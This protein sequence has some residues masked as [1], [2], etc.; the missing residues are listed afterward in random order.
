MGQ[1]LRVGRGARRLSVILAM[2][3]P[4]GAEGAFREDSHLRL[5][6]RN[7][8]LYRNFTESGAPRS[9]VGD[10]SQGFDLRFTSGYT[11]TPIALGLDIDGQYAARLGSHGDDGSLVYSHSKEKAQS[12]GR[13]GATFKARYSKTELKVGN[14][15]PELPIA[16]HDVT[17]Q[18]DTIFQGAVLESK[19]VGGLTLTGGRFWSVVTRESSNREK[20]YLMGHDSHMDSDGMDFG[21]ATYDVTKNFQVSYF[22]ALAHDLYRQHYLGLRENIDLGDDYLL[23][24]D[25]RGF[26]SRD[27][28]NAYSGKI[29][30]RVL[31]SGATLSK[32][33]HQFTVGY[34]RMYGS[35]MFPLLN[36]Y[37]PQFYLV[38][39][40]LQ[41]FSYRGEDTYSVRYF[42]DF[43]HTGLPGLTLTAR[44]VQGSSFTQQGVGTNA[45]ES[46]RDFF[47]R[48]VIP[49]GPLKGLGVEWKN[50]LVHQRNFGSSF[51]ENRLVT[52]YTWNIW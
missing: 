14:M 13:F 17:R 41:P 26:S 33:G 6:F 31:S 29:D 8:Y 25:M 16:Y 2:A 49:D 39:W 52:T 23:R 11:G 4:F 10:W 35:T 37:I 15:R 18:L 48:Y 12:Y 45:R 28:G 9:Q 22:Y 51:E 21:G 7:F 44:Y 5:D 47:V 3:A 42:Y 20:L 30:N 32:A 38:N 27:T 34:Q 40:A 1:T 43:A 50:F 24:L 36:G 46:E 19:E